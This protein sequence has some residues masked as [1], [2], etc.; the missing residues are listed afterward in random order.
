MQRSIA[1]SSLCQLYREDVAAPI[2]GLSTDQWAGHVSRRRKPLHSEL[3]GLLAVFKFRNVFRPGACA[4]Q[5]QHLA[6]GCYSSHFSLALRA[7]NCPPALNV[8]VLRAG[9]SQSKEWR[10]SLRLL[11]VPGQPHAV[12]AK[13]LLGWQRGLVKSLLY[14]CPGHTHNVQCAY[15]SDSKFAVSSAVVIV[16]SALFAASPEP[17]GPRTRTG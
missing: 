14:C 17:P 11:D 15:V 2:F 10:T 4:V 12:R 7:C 1:L 8:L 13:S 9:S 6:R 16:W 3:A 5:P